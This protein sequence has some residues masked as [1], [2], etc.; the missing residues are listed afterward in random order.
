MNQLLLSPID[1]L[2]NESAERLN[3]MISARMIDDLSKDRIG[4]LVRANKGREKES[5][6]TL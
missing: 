2:S 4:T 6:G 5:A 3:W 1:Y